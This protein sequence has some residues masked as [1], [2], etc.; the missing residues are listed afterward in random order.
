[1]LIRPSLLVLLGASIQ[2]AD[3]PGIPVPGRIDTPEFVL[4]GGD[5]DIGPEGGG[6]GDDWRVAHGNA[7]WD[8]DW[9]SA[10]IDYSILTFKNLNGAPYA[11]GANE[12]STAIAPGS[13]RSDEITASIAFRAT[14]DGGTW[15]SWAQAGP[16]IQLSGDFGGRSIQN[17][18]H[19]V[20]GNPPSNLP[21]EHPGLRAAGLVHAGAGGRTQVAGPFMIDA[22]AMDLETSGGWNRWRA[23][24]MVLAA[25]HGGGVWAGLRQDGASGHALTPI[26]DQVAKHEA[27][28]DLVVGMSWH[29]EDFQLSLETSHNFDNGGQDGY[30]SLAYTPQQEGSLA[31]AGGNPQRWQVRLGLSGEDSRVPGYG[32]DIELG[33]SVDGFPKWLQFVIGIREQDMGLPFV[34]D[35]SGQRIMTWTGLEAESIVL[36]SPSANIFVAAE[37]GV[38][39]RNDRV[40]S[41][42]YENVDGNDSANFTTPIVRAAAG[43]G[44]SVSVGE[45][46]YGLLLLAEA[47][48]AVK[49]DVVLNVHNAVNPDVLSNSDVVHLDGG[50]IGFIFACTMSWQ[51]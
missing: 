20:I 11:S 40:V 10:A 25:G 29:I 19:A 47:T 6:S 24:G 18:F 37:G 41:H 26:A 31:Q 7:D 36:G 51:W 38:G 43:L 23:E 4:E 28:L 13:G 22:R 12:S 27:G 14:Y 34:Y 35:F 15:R 8:H 17:E 5:S 9:I 49:R 46:H 45:A 39:V 50:S 32:T 1:M 2:A 48:A 16:G 30:I 42:G 33:T 3:L 21:Y 44:G